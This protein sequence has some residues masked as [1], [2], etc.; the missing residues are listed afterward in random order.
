MTLT[1]Q[2]A[3][4]ITRPAPRIEVYL[5]EEAAPHASVVAGAQGRTGIIIF[6]G[7]GYGGLADYEG[8]AY[9]RYLAAH[10]FSCFV[11]SY[12]L[13]TQGFRHPAMLEDALS[14]IA[15]VRGRTAALGVDP[16]RIGVMGSSAGGHLAAHSMVAFGKYPSAVPL[17]P[18]FGVLCYPVI[19]KREGLGHAG[20]RANLLGE[21][22]AD[23]A[24]DETSCDLH[25]TAATPPCFL[26]HT[27]DDD[28]VSFQNSMR[29]AAALHREGVDF[30][31]HIFDSGPH[32]MGQDLTHP[33][34]ANL[35]HWLSSR[36]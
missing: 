5:A 16:H 4:A 30:E 32:G 29:F 7:G 9:A 11:V 34:A 14:A 13:G 26:W 19:S 24:A 20:S 18:D 1:G 28:V 2:L 3:G 35:V 36:R 22:P 10:G 15:V 17:R 6:P 25:V 31:M 21:S 33:W 8:E 23:D 27:R 12:R